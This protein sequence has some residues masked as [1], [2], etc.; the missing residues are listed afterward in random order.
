MRLHQTL[1]DSC[2]A[3]VTDDR[4]WWQEVELEDDLHVRGNI[5]IVVRASYQKQQRTQA[6][7][8]PYKLGRCLCL[9]TV[10]RHVFRTYTAP[11]ITS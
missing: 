7:S 10:D 3:L 6:N 9:R 11:Q 1:A 8:L 2:L 5:K 4:R